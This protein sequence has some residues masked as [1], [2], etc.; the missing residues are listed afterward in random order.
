MCED[1]AECV[2]PSA[3][4]SEGRCECE[5]SFIPSAD[6]SQCNGNWFVLPVDLL[7]AVIELNLRTN[8]KLYVISGLT[9]F[10][11]VILPVLK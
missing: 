6:S 1:N 10:P 3:V 11:I 4:C 9:R 8:V 7:Y 2:I 5:P